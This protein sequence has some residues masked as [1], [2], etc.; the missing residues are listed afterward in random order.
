MT[1]STRHHRL[2]G[3]EPDNLL[4]FL[5]LLG[6][7]RALETADA[8]G[9]EP[10]TRLL[11]RVAWDFKDRP[12]RPVLYLACALT[13]EQVAEAAIRGL[14]RLASAYDF[15]GRA[16]LD[17]S[18]AE[19]RE[20]LDLAARTSNARERYR[21]DLLA[22]LMI[23]AAVRPG[24]DPDA[25]P[26]EPTPL[27]LQF[28]QGRQHFLDRLTKVANDDLRPVRGGRRSLPRP[29]STDSIVEALFAP[30]RRADPTLSFRWDPAEDVRYAL[31]P[32]DPT[33]ETYKARTQ[34]G[35]NRL[36]VAGVAALTVAPA[37]RGERVRLRV[38]GGSVTRDG[39]AFAWPVWREPATLSTIRALLGHPG[40]WKPGGLEHLGVAFVYTTRR[41]SVGKFMN[42]SQALVQDWAL[43]S[44][45]QGRLAPVSGDGRAGTGFA[46]PRVT[47]VRWSR[48]KGKGRTDA[49]GNDDSAP[50]GDS[51][52]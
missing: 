14:R 5:A 7:L 26:V 4:A 46:E 6:L 21:S 19:C 22:A 49:D 15:A 10:A 8:E 47:V 43:G 39:F 2:V 20:L 24:R 25:S 30:W 34:H 40:L 38:L 36:A 42:F 37:T 11:P 50:D 35:A 44:T 29:S 48:P 1:T 12:L 27:C 17:Y 45:A 18:G 32:G 31:L 51:E 41:I 28:G 33:D 9:P 52:A 23:D 3:L 16:N 13:Q